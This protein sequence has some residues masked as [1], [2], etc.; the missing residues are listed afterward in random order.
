MEICADAIRRN[1]NS[2]QLIRNKA[3][4]FKVESSCSLKMM[5]M[6]STDYTYVPNKLCL[7]TAEARKIKSSSYET[8]RVSFESITVQLL[9]EL[10]K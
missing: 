6:N 10:F 5:Q 8:I 1:K 7:F 3:N 2:V 4:L 9:R